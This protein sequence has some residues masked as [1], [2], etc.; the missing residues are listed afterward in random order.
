MLSFD[1]SAREM[2]LCLFK[3]AGNS[4]QPAL[5][6]VCDENDFDAVYRF[7]HPLR[8]FDVRSLEYA[9]QK[10]YREHHDIDSVLV[11]EAPEY[12]IADDLVQLSTNVSPDVEIRWQ[13]STVS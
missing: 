3:L 12:L 5:V 1:G 4:L 7:R 8:I 9:I 11:I 2:C 6:L 13:S 10:Y